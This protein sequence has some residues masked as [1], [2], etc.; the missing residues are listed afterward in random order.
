MAI[1]DEMESLGEG[2]KGPN[3]DVIGIAGAVDV[4]LWSGL[5]TAFISGQ[6]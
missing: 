5:T 2:H 3:R 6:G 4:S 1:K